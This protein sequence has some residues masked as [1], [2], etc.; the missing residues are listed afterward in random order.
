MSL[1]PPDLRAAILSSSIAALAPDGVFV[2]YGYLHAKAFVY[3]LSAASLA[4]I[5]RPTCSLTSPRSS[6]G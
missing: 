6:N 5:W 3:S 2:Q 1:L 4:S